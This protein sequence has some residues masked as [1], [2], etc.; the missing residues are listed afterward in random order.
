MLERATA[1]LKTGAARDSLRCTQ[2]ASKSRRMLHSTFWNHGAGALDLPPCA[3]SM[4]PMPS[5]LPLKHDSDILS[6][7]RSRK[8]TQPKVAT[9]GVFLDFLYP[10]QALA[11][12]QRASKPQHTQRWEKRNIGRLPDGFVVAS[13]GYTSSSYRGVESHRSASG[14]EQEDQRPVAAYKPM[15]SPVQES[16]TGQ[17]PIADTAEAD[18]G[19]VNGLNTPD[20]HSRAHRN[21][22][23]AYSDFDETFADSPGDLADVA[24]NRLSSLRH[25]ITINRGKDRVEDSE[26]S[27]RLI[28]RAWTTY[29][30]LDEGIRDDSRLKLE[31]LSWLAMHR[32]DVATSYCEELYQ[33]ISTGQRTLEIYDAML[34]MYLRQRDWES[35]SNLHHECLQILENGYVVSRRLFQHA[36]EQQEWA[37]AVQTASQHHNRYTELNQTNQIRLFWLHVSEMPRLFEKAAQLLNHFKTVDRLREAGS[38]TRL[39]CLR[40]FKE[41]VYQLTADAGNPNNRFQIFFKHPERRR[42]APPIF[43]FVAEMDNNPTQILG[44]ALVALVNRGTQDYWNY[45]DVVSGVY[46]ELRKLPNV[47]PSQRLLSAFL[48]RLTFYEPGRHS[49]Q[50]SEESVTTQTI[51]RDWKLYYGKLSK[52]A[53][54]RLLSS[55]AWAGRSDQVGYWMDDFRSAYPD[56]HHWKDSLWALVYLHARRTN[57]DQAQQA[58]AEVKRIAAEHGDEPDIKCWSVLLY[59]H[60]RADDLEGAFTNFHNLLQ[61]TKVKLNQSCFAPIFAMLA[62]RGNVEGLDD[63]M[64]QHDE[65]VGDKRDTMMLTH[66]INARV[67]AGDIDA[68]EGVLREAISQKSTR[69]IPGPLTPCFNAVM[70]AYAD[71]HDMKNA[72]KTYH[73]M[74]EE[75]TQLN[76]DSFAILIRVLMADHRWQAAQKILWVEMPQHRAIPTAFHYAVIMRGMVSLNLYGQAIY[77]Y[78]SM[79]KDGIKSSVAANT[80]YLQAKAL[81]EDVQQKK[82]PENHDPNAPLDK[83]IKELEKMLETYDG[84]EVATDQLSFLVGTIDNTAA[85]PAPYFETLIQIHGKRRCFEAVDSLFARYKE[86]AKG[87]GGDESKLPLGLTSKLM[88]THWHAGEYDQV[89]EYWKLAKERADEVAPPVPVPSFRYFV[90]E[91]ELESADPLTLHPVT[92]QYPPPGPESENHQESGDRPPK[93][94]KQTLLIDKETSMKIRPAASRRHILNQPLRWYLAALNSQSRIV[95]A[96]ATVSRLL[97]QGY[98]MDKHTWN[99]FI[100]FLLDTSTPLALLA[101]ILTDRFLTPGFAGWKTGMATRR[102]ARRQD[103]YEGVEYMKARFVERGRLMP[104]YTTLVRLGGALLDI[105]RL[106]SQ[107]RRGFNSDIPRE[108]ERFV[109][110]TR[111]IRRLAAKTLHVVQSMPYVPDRIQAKHLR[112]ER[113]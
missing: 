72:M 107:G 54:A 96:I 21:E 82:D 23:Q 87:R 9:D 103:R 86:F 42:A 90:A 71:R 15:V 97:T 56:Y 89:E 36:V 84:I 20:R 93:E 17:E 95:D 60:G 3:V 111:D 38:D 102:P 22:Q 26:K 112:R 51:V 8:K 1:C 19:W 113:I 31:L 29:R 58:F 49:T 40:F 64:E 50:A 41:A 109:G 101:F 32:S 45:H 88:S 46:W 28:Q 39:F 16:D 79:I 48:Y 69:A 91:K 47:K 85:D 74:K 81:L 98:T 57:L 14:E 30:S 65:I 18:G 5:D 43:R 11:W 55:N 78:N 7:V 12:L 6:G 59:A 44:D 73:W 105:R 80:L 13:R 92:D 75:G 70:K 83:S 4:L 37:L 24:P 52:E 53:Y 33:S 35:A 25:L 94:T 62:N 67:H 63:F 104:Q 100:C 99:V 68:A 27:R 66:L 108:L 34:S 77:L 10:P 76:P 61:S 106:E 110:T 2:K